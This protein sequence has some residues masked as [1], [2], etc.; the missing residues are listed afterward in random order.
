[1]A[2]LGVT[3]IAGISRVS[4]QADDCSV[5]YLDGDL[6]NRQTNYRAFADTAEFAFLARIEVLAEQTVLFSQEQGGEIETGVAA[7]KLA[8]RRSEDGVLRAE[9]SAIQWPITALKVDGQLYSVIGEAQAQGVPV[10]IIFSGG[11]EDIGEILFEPGVFD[12]QT[13]TID[14]NAQVSGIM[15]EAMM[16]RRGFSVRLVA[17]GTIYSSIQPETMAYADFIESTLLPAMDEARRMEAEGGCSMM[18]DEAMQMYLEMME[19]DCF[20]TSACC[21]V[22]GLNDRRWELETLRKFRDGWLSSFAEGRADIARYYREAP[23][24][25][26][27]LVSSPAG[28]RRLLGLYWRYIIPS[29]LLVKAGANRMAHRLYRKMMVDLLG[30]SV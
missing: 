7:I 29:A 3:S 6:D 20:L 10:G 25:A 17:G 27:L 11:G 15:H 22:I 12:P 1:M 21:A 28:R 2:A 4:A 13:E 9:K 19:E 5:S 18:S 14:F 23:A 30:P 16:Q 8:V 26:Q 24:V